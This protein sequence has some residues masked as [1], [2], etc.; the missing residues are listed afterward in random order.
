MLNIK[1]LGPGCRNCYLLEQITVEAL[2]G[3]AKE[4]PDL[5]AT[6]QH[7]TDYE[8]MMKYPLLFT[9]GLVVNEKLVSAGRLPPPEEIRGWLEAAL[10]DAMT[11]S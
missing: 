1:I 7:V 9:P 2:E 5:E 10:N 8:E 6:L 11:S 4:Q 3:L